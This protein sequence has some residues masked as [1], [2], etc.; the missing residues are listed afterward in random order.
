MV[1]ILQK[2]FLESLPMCLL[3]GYKLKGNQVEHLSSEGDTILIK[4]MS[5]Y[6]PVIYSLA[7]CITTT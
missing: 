7:H 1:T 2:R 4:V 6:Y 3:Y 5:I